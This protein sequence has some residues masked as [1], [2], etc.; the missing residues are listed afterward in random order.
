MELQE[1]PQEKRGLGNCRG[2]KNKHY[3]SFTNGKSYYCEDCANKMMGKV[4]EPE[5]IPKAGLTSDFFS[6]LPTGE[7]FTAGEDANTHAPL[8]FTLNPLK[9]TNFQIGQLTSGWVISADG[10][11]HVFT[12]RTGVIEF[13]KQFLR[14]EYE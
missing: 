3:C 12:S 11:S 7:E 9:T 6:K 13:L 4:K 1:I 10:E 2:C 14:G 8:Q 5:V